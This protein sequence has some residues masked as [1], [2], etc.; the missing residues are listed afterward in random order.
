[1]KMQSSRWLLIDKTYGS[2]YILE[3]RKSLFIVFPPNFREGCG[4]EQV[5]LGA[6]FLKDRRQTML[7]GFFVILETIQGQMLKL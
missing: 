1:M 4:S 3:N 6:Q 7:S 5:P 2:Y